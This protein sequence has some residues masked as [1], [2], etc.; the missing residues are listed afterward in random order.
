MLQ[1]TAVPIGIIT[2]QRPRHGSG[3]FIGMRL[4]GSVTYFDACDTDLPPFNVTTFRE[5]ISG[6]ANHGRARD[7]TPNPNESTDALLA[8]AD[9]AMYQAKN[10]GKN[11]V[12]IA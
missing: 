1:K 3:S 4:S 7:A 5:R 6:G 8:R 9:N 11:C 12:A 2:M 10:A